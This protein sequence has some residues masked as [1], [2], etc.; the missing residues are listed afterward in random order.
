MPMGPQMVWNTHTESLSASDSQTWLQLKNLIIEFEAVRVK[1]SNS[2]FGL[3]RSFHR[4][5]IVL[6][7]VPIDIWIGLMASTPSRT[8]SRATQ[9]RD[10]ENLYS[11]APIDVQ[12][13]D[14]EFWAYENRPRN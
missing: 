9:V 10:F 14:L 5:M 7:T 12:A 3:Y 11:T 4:A 6:T 13:R 2:R 1:M 8:P